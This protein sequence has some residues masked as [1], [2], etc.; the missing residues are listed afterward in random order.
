MIAFNHFWM[1]KWFLP[2]H[3]QKDLQTPAHL[4]SHRLPQ[5]G[6]SH[7]IM[8]H[9]NQNVSIVG[10]MFSTV[11]TMGKWFF[12]VKMLLSQN[13]RLTAPNNSSLFCLGKNG[14]LERICMGLFERSQAWL[15]IKALRANANLASLTQ[16]LSPS[17][18]KR[19]YARRPPNGGV[20][21]D[22]IPTWGR[23]EYW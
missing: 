14:T 9:F 7:Q 1:D 17:H 18:A 5:V 8:L 2:T 12:F 23:G 19:T 21:Q 4:P 11:Q 3:F 10:F 13:P 20:T 16:S 22:H 6:P 15:R